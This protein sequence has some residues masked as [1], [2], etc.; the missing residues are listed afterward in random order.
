MR[1]CRLWTTSTGVGRALVSQ[2]IIEVRVFPIFAWLPFLLRWSV[3]FSLQEPEMKAPHRSLVCRLLAVGALSAW[4]ISIAMVEAGAADPS[5]FDAAVVGAQWQAGMRASV[6]AHAVP[7]GMPFGSMTPADRRQAI[8]AIWGP[9]AP[10]AEKHAIFDK[11][12]SYVDAHYAAFQN[13][14]VDWAALRDKYR[15]EVAAGVSRGRIA[16][17]MNQL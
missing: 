13:I 11:F 8:D 15:P 10:T 9:G 6:A 4:S 3:S 12:W 1:G 17:I 5:A 16:A 2:S 14:N 7:A